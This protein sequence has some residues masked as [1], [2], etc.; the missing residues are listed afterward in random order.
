MLS[1]MKLLLCVTGQQDQPKKKR[2]DQIRSAL[3]GDGEAEPVQGVREE[4][5]KYSPVLVCEG[6]T[7]LPLCAHIT[8]ITQ[9]RTGTTSLSITEKNVAKLM[10]V[11][12]RASPHCLKRRKDTLQGC[13]LGKGGKRES[14]ANPGSCNHCLSQA[15]KQ[16]R[17]KSAAIIPKGVGNTQA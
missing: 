2:R 1:T 3:V 9:Q 12:P 7:V 5:K 4:R 16:W 11:L 10:K 8:Q 15:K 14:T 13:F 6:P 17:K